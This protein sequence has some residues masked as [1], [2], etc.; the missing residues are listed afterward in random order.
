M[1]KA[2]NSYEFRMTRMIY[3]DLLP[4]DRQEVSFFCEKCTNRFVDVH[5][6][7]K[8]SGI[9]LTF[10]VKN[11]M[12]TLSSFG[13]VTGINTETDSGKWDGIEMTEGNNKH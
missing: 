2:L 7:M 5:E 1:T 9:E 6:Y 8:E 13:N 10:C 11:A 12:F 4:D 3:G